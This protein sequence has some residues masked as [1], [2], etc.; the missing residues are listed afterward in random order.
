M[1]FTNSCVNHTHLSY[2][3]YLSIPSDFSAKLAADPL[4]GA[5]RVSERRAGCLSLSKL[6]G[7]LLVGR[8]TEGRGSLSDLQEMPGKWRPGSR[9]PNILYKYGG[10]ERWVV[11]FQ[12]GDVPRFQPLIWSGVFV[13]HQTLQ[14][15]HRQNCQHDYDML[16][17]DEMKYIEI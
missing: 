1:N 16:W 5:W 17:E 2:H 9:H 12:L 14:G 4:P 6:Q 10:L 7:D 15:E 3:L 8:G 13:N 11:P